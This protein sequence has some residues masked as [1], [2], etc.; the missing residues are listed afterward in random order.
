MQVCIELAASRVNTRDCESTCSLLRFE[1]KNMVSFSGIL[2]N[3]FRTQYTR[4]NH[5]TDKLR[6]LTRAKL[7]MRHP[8]SVNKHTNGTHTLPTEQRTF[9]MH[10]CIFSMYRC[11]LRLCTQSKAHGAHTETVSK[12]HQRKCKTNF[13]PPSIL[14]RGDC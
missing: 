13:G 10:R 1:S 7:V 3:T 11:V 9:K 8:L 5:Y 6:A 4:I 14:P 2:P 12:R